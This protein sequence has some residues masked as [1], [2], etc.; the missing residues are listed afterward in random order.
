MIALVQRCSQSSV[1]IEGNRVA[2]IG[3]GILV[4]LG[5]S[6]EDAE[7]DAVWLAKKVSN[8]RIFADA[9]GKMN[10]SLL[11]SDGQALV[12]SQFTLLADT[13]MGNRPAYIKAARPEQA[14]PL[15]ELFVKEL[16]T[17]LQKPIP[18]GVFGADMQVSLVNDGPVTIWVESKGQ[19]PKL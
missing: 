8:L 17:H 16:G 18:I 12:V 15:Y 2:E 6:I 11:D 7:K 10:R 9:D 5:V 1:T 3:A 14:I 13:S 4:L 19:S